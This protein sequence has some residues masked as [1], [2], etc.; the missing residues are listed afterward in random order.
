M[1]GRR[2]DNSVIPFINL[3]KLE[4]R[5][6]YVWSLTAPKSGASQNS[7]K[8]YYLTEH[9]AFL[10]PYLKGGDMSSNLDVEESNTNQNW[11]DL[12][13]KIIIKVYLLWKQNFNMQTD[14]HVN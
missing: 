1:T 3:V 14:K 4:I 12:L 11:W 7:K 5:T 10:Q 2:E 13:F 9:L 8:S 6:E